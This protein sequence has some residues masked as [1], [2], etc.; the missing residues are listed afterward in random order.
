MQA[1][2]AWD[3][4][5]PADIAPGG[6]AAMIGYRDS[7]GG[8]MDIRVGGI[9]AV[10]MLIGFGDE[11]LVVENAAGRQAVTGFVT[12][13][14]SGGMRISS[15]RAECVEVRLSPPR[16]H[17]LLGIDPAELGSAVVEL[18]DLWGERAVRLRE[19]LGETTLWE[20]RFALTRAFLAECAEPA[21][22]PDPEVV[23][24][25][26]RIL[27]SH[28]RV[29]VGELAESCGWSRKRL[30]ARFESQLGL[31]PKRAA[32]LVRFRYAVDGLLTGL[33]AAEVA[34]ACGYTDQPHLCRDMSNF[35]NLTPG[36]LAAQPRTEVMR[37]RNRAWGTFFQYRGRLVDR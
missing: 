12:G 4:A 17:S 37:Y 7:R 36:A 9:P 30:W 10:T 8:G 31:T 2:T 19:R 27:V 29:R 1:D 21:R 35:A 33:P 15:A 22:L 25:W 6:G 11:D 3:F 34:A 13:Y 26:R 18:T 23:A 16:A 24:S 20:E 32:M 28:G 5:R 14:S